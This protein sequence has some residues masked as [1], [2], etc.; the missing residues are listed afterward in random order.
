MTN[1]NPSQLENAF[2]AA[3]RVMRTE[4]ESGGT[5]AKALAGTR[6]ILASLDT[7]DAKVELA[8]RELELERSQA[9]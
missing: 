9:I 8:A 3:A 1:Q 7:D 5:S 2:Y 4:R 6:T